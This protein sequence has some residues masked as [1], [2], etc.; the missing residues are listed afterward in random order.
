L[1]DY[2]EHRE[3]PN[4]RMKRLIPLTFVFVLAQCQA[5]LALG[6]N[7]FRLYPACGSRGCDVSFY[8]STLSGQ[9]LTQVG[10]E[11]GK[12]YFRRSTILTQGTYDF[13]Q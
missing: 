10:F 7:N 11:G 5:H 8:A 12:F 13:I 4:D 6:A 9:N 2:C 1:C 3:V